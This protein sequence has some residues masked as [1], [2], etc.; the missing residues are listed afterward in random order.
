MA[1]PAESAFWLETFRDV[2]EAAGS[3][4]GPRARR[5]A[6]DRRRDRRDRARDRSRAVIEPVG[7][8]EPTSRAHA[9]DELSVG[10]DAFIAQP[11][12]APAGNSAGNRGKTEPSMV[13]SPRSWRGRD[14]HSRIRIV[15]R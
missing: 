1:T 10:I 7:R 15:A 3:P 2:T 4:G 8:I 12:P 6:L 9:V 14:S 11:R 13:L 5:L